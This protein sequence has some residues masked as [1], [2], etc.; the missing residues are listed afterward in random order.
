M[1]CSNPTDTASFGQCEPAATTTSGCP[2]PGQTLH[3]SSDQCAITFACAEQNT[4]VG[5]TART[6][7]EGPECGWFVSPSQSGVTAAAHTGCY[8]AQSTDRTVLVTTLQH[9]CAL[10]VWVTGEVHY[11]SNAG[12]IGLAIASFLLLFWG[13]RAR[14]G[15][16]DPTASGG[17]ILEQASLII[18]G[19]PCS[20]A[21]VTE[22]FGWRLGASDGIGPGGN[23]E[24]SYPDVWRS[25]SW[26]TP[27]EKERHDAA[28]ERKIAA[29]RR[30]AAAAAAAQSGSRKNK[31]K[32]QKQQAALTA[33]AAAAE[34][35]SPDDAAGGVHVVSVQVSPSPPQ[36]ASAPRSKYLLLLH[37]LCTGAAWQV[38]LWSDAAIFCI[39]SLSLFV[40]RWYLTPGAEEGMPG[41]TLMGQEIV[42]GQL[43]VGYG[44]SKPSKT[45]CSVP[46]LQYLASGGLCV[47]IKAMG[48]LI[49]LIGLLYFFLLV[50][51]GYTDLYAWLRNVNLV[52][53]HEALLHRSRASSSAGSDGAVDQGEDPEL[54]LE[55]GADPTLDV[56]AAMAGGP[57]RRRPLRCC[58]HCGCHLRLVR[59]FLRLRYACMYAA[60]ILL[61]P[62]VVY[63]LLLIS[64]GFSVVLG[65]GNTTLHG[66]FL[67]MIL[68]A[69]V[70][71]AMLLYEQNKM[72]KILQ[73]LDERSAER[74]RRR[75]GEQ[76]D[77]D[78]EKA[79]AVG[80]SDGASPNGTG[81][82]GGARGHGRSSHF[83]AS[84][85][86]LMSSHLATSHA[87]HA[88]GAGLEF[89]DQDHAYEIDSRGREHSLAAPSGNG[90]SGGGRWKEINLRDH[91]L[92]DEEDEMQRAERATVA[93]AH[94]TANSATEM[95]V[96]GIRP[97]SVS[98]SSPAHSAS[99]PLAASASSG[100]VAGGRPYL[101]NHT[102]YEPQLELDEMADEDEL[103]L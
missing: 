3:N 57:G 71:L 66:S 90:S 11:G 52:A 70:E 81:S 73:R 50:T 54:D 10:D 33:A 15:F 53:R 31:A 16:G 91:P 9:S 89:E 20:A 12:W 69:L 56:L 60:W 23:D 79:A 99:P 42:W 43:L 88:D 62:L 102:S 14:S 25:S 7:V 38:T 65:T 1:W 27:A 24:R 97:P 45:D 87:L 64:D 92:I 37:S 40:D 67:G 8:P 84:S 75:R 82:G 103:E 35:G 76:T 36:A 51:R 80:G 85:S 32:R 19:P 44:G 39:F 5:C 41:A 46:P 34:S 21:M 83:P 63:R 95:S 59:N 29:E 72:G 100:A 26:L 77:D 30:K 22:Y 86:S 2:L 68:V 96:L 6:G 74:H 93:R 48:V 55:G 101:T 58:C 18:L 98:S 49:Y 47:A 4:C 78:E 17:G 28:M 13:C 61:L 94:A